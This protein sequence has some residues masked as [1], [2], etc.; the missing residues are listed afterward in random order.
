MDVMSMTKLVKVAD[1]LDRLNSVVMGFSNTGIYDKFDNLGYVY[2]IIK[3]YSVYKNVEC[4][5]YDEMYDI[6]EDKTKTPEERARIM[7]GL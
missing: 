3:E 7:L 4:D 6:L 2:D 1:D 5:S